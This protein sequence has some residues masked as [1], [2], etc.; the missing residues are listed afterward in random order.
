[1]LPLRGLARALFEI[2]ILLALWLGSS[3]APEGFINIIRVYS[4]L[5]YRQ[6]GK[7]ASP[8]FRVYAVIW[9]CNHLFVDYLNMKLGVLVC[10]GYKAA[11]WV[12]LNTVSG[13]FGNKL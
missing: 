6:G 4:L 3:V 5:A 13:G 7:T 11:F 1:V 10:F 8:V 9:R 2:W 12:L